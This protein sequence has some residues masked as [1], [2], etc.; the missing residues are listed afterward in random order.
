MDATGHPDINFK[1]MFL[2]FFFDVIAN[3]VGV[4]YFGV[5]GA[6]AGTAT[7]YLVVFT[8]TQIILN[9]MFGIKWLNVFKNTFSFYG[10]ILNM[11]KMNLRP[12]TQ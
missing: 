12:K 8:T 9:R 11:A 1:V 10:E 4:H 5:I 7:T 2:A 3:L 6:A